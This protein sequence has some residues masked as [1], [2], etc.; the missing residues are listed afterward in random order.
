MKLRLLD[1]L[2]LLVLL[3]VS[4]TAAYYLIPA[5]LT[6]T[7]RCYEA[8]VNGRK[9]GFV[10]RVCNDGDG[11]KWRYVVFVPYSLRE[12]EKLPVILYLNGLGKRGTDGFAQLTDGL[13]PSLWEAKATFPFIALFPQCPADTTW[14]ADDALVARTMDL[15]DT[16]IATYH[17]DP[18]RVFV[19]GLSSGGS[20]VWRFAEL[21]P[22]RFAG[23][24]PVS[25]PG[26]GP[27]VQDLLI[28]HHVPIWSFHVHNDPGVVEGCR[29]TYRAF[30][31]KGG[32][33]R[34]TEI[35]GLHARNTHNGWDFA[36]RNAAL[37]Q[38]MS[39]QNRSANQHETKKFTPLLLD[40]DDLGEWEPVGSEGTI[41]D[42][43]VVSS[44][45]A[46]PQAVSSLRYKNSHE[47]Y[48][49]HLD[50][51]QAGR[52]DR[53]LEFYSGD[54][55]LAGL[56]LCIVDSEH[57]SGGIVD[58]TDGRCLQAANP[59]AQRAIIQDGWND[60]RL[61]IDGDQMTV[62]VN[63]WPLHSLKDDRITALNGQ[64]ALCAPSDEANAA[65]WRYIRIR[66]RE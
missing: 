38:W 33:P 32:S 13:A 14:T 31:E 1:Y 4:A 51:R 9:R 26:C 48:Q 27:R 30:V 41:S 3:G 19:T 10:A 64:L 15:L 52:K 45:N 65:L 2:I 57:G 43:G 6:W 35:N 60:L 25:S 34:F 20:G 16:T 7:D 22:D 17:A 28:E 24:I 58:L 11:K 37:Y 8:A 12:E 29:S 63:G 18:D 53:R 36:F 50:F 40:W 39:G 5:C 23:I 42:G 59:V 21:Y 47:D 49:L 66:N 61:E 55:S 46:H 62:E 44:S 54:D 56:R